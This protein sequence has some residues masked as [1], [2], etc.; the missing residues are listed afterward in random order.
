MDNLNEG[1]LYD[2]K[3][4]KGIEDR[5]KWFEDF[6]GE[7]IWSDLRKKNV[8]DCK[9]LLERIQQH[10][11]VFIWLGNDASEYVWKCAVVDFLKDLNVDIYSIDWQNVFGYN[12]RGQEINLGYLSICNPENAFVAGQNFRV[13]AKNEKQNLIDE[14]NRIL[15]NNTDLRNLNNGTLEE[16]DISF[17]DEM[18]INRCNNEFQAGPR[19][20]GFTLADMYFK[21][22]SG[23]IGDFFL[24]ERL[25][26]LAEMGKLEIAELV[27]RKPDAANWFKVRFNN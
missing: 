18:L 27:Y 15:I 5:V 10:D 7:D 11:R 25:E 2:L 6:Y 13:L 17:F 4:L 12:V 14:W 9:L 22:K 1:K 26:Q 16:G 3:T 24:F 8:K 20:V 19:V 23:G 21:F